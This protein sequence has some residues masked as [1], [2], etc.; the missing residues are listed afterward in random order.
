MES[1]AKPLVQNDPD[2]I[3]A[4][5]DPSISMDKPQLRK[6]TSVERIEAALK[7]ST[8]T[9]LRKLVWSYAEFD[10]YNTVAEVLFIPFTALQSVRAVCFIALSICLGIFFFIKVTTGFHFYSFHTLLITTV[11]FFF[12]FIEFGKQ[13]CF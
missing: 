8:C 5:V 6:N 7:V 13:K 1:F 3:Y 11:A 4:E 9:R 2:K 12:L 10:K